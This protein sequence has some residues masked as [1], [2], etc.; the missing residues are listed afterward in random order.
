MKFMQDVKDILE[1]S[2]KHLDRLCHWALK[3]DLPVKVEFSLGPNLGA[4]EPINI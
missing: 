2:G 3:W 4:M 1:D